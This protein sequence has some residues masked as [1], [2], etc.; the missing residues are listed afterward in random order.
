VK[1][2][3]VV[4]EVATSAVRRFM[5]GRGERPVAVK[6]MVPVSVRSEREQDALGNR[7]SF[8]FV[9]LPC[10]EPDPVRR[11]GEIHGDTDVRKRKGFPEGG[12][13][14]VGLLGLVPGPIQRLASRMIASPRTF[15]L[16][17]SNIPGP[18]GEAYLRGCRLRE[19]YPVVP[20]ADRHTLSI[21]FTS[22]DDRACFGVYADRDSLPDVDDLGACI[23]AAIDELLVPSPRRE[24]PVPVLG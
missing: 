17:V 6:A 7:I 1:L 12:D 23:D 24:P 21:G 20:L 11:L 15:N 19:A 4:L 13:D 10:D 3:D 16:V 9:D 8:M 14:V 2:N 5:S 22:V 18:Q